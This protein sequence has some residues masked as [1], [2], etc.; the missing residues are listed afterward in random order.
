MTRGRT[1]V[2]SHSIHSCCTY[3]VSCAVCRVLSATVSVWSICIA[4]WRYLISHTH[5]YQFNVHEMCHFWFYISFWL[6]RITIASHNHHRIAYKEKIYIFYAIICGRC[7]MCIL[8]IFIDRHTCTKHS[9]S[10]NTYTLNTHTHP[11]VVVYA[12]LSRTNSLHG[13]K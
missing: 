7:L 10:H 1:R 9:L 2:Y 6:I 13:R 4:L 12:A 5:S 11:Q 3:I 8:F